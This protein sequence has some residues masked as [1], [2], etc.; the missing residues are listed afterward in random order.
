MAA[1]LKAAPPKGARGPLYG[2]DGKL[3]QQWKKWQADGRLDANAGIYCACTDQQ[4]LGSR[5]LAPGVT[6]RW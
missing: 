2:V 5:K 4:P 6:C 1:L 3:K